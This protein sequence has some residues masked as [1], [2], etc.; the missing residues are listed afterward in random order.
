MCIWTWLYIVCAVLD[1]GRNSHIIYTANVEC[2]SFTLFAT[3]LDLLWRWNGKCVEYTFNRYVYFVLC[4]GKLAFVDCNS[5]HTSS[6]TQHDMQLRAQWYP[7]LVFKGVCVL[8]RDVDL[9]SLRCVHWTTLCVRSADLNI[10]YVFTVHTFLLRYLN[11]FYK[12]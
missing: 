5:I 10:A 3:A 2:I 6:I 7:K 8:E 12:N 9:A 11:I 1:C 4:A